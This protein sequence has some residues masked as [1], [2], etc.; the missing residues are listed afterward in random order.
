MR[1]AWHQRLEPIQS[2]NGYFRARFAQIDRGDLFL[3]LGGTSGRSQIDVL[4]LPHDR[5]ADPI[6][7][8]SANR[9]EVTMPGSMHYAPTAI[10][11]ENCAYQT[12]AVRQLSFAFTGEYPQRDH[13]IW[14]YSG[15]FR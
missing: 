10:W 11:V 7:W 9:I 3:V 6:D 2:F 1:D 12:T 8:N 5:I 13:E 4:H 14:F 15:S